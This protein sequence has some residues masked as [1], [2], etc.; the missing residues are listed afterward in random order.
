MNQPGSWIVSV[1]IS[2]EKH[3]CKNDVK[4]GVLKEEWG[5][6]GDSHA[7]PGIR[8]VSL[9]A[10]ESIMK[11]KGRGVELTPGIFGENLTTEGIDLQSLQ[12]GDRFRIGDEAVL[13]VTKLGK[14]CLKPCSI[15]YKVGFCVMPI[16]GIFARVVKGGEVRSGDPIE[17]LG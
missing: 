5:L 9:L 12:I 4:R 7:G 15:Y 10:V 16:E 3:V 17:L 1:C 13:E 2:A 14:E 6:E 11:M 8:Q